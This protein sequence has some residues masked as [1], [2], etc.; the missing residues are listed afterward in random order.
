MSNTTK[1]LPA[2]WSHFP[3]SMPDLVVTFLKKGKTILTIIAHNWQIEIFIL[4]DLRC[5]SHNLVRLS[6]WTPFSSCRKHMVIL[7]RVCGFQA[8]QKHIKMMVILLLIRSYKLIKEEYWMKYTACRVLWRSTTTD[9]VL[10]PTF[11]VDFTEKSRFGMV[12]VA[13]ANQ[14]NKCS[15]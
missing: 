13:V 9:V 12:T 5:I 8:Q 7:K 11:D 6:V 2:A 15:Q 3:G 4:Q 10:T 14:C 1:R